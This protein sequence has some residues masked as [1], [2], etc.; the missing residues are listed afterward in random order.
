MVESIV[1]QEFPVRFPA[2]SEFCKI[3]DIAVS[4]FTSC[5]S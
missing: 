3:K 5:L 4:S 2:S 1:R